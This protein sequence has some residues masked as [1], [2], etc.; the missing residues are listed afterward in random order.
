MTNERLDTLEQ[1]AK[2]LRDD[3]DS[4]LIEKELLLK[5]IAVARAAEEL[6]KYL[7]C[8]PSVSADEIGA[9]ADMKK[10]LN[11]VSDDT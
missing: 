11:G 7:P 8:G 2:S 9:W 4:L 10:A 3:L 1:W 6:M 5:L